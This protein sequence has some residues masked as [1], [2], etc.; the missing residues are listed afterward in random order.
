MGEN[1]PLEAP[2]LPEGPEA[3]AKARELAPALL[4]VNYGT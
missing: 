3:K 4:C 1:V 2:H